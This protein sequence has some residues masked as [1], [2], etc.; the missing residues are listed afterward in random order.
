[1]DILGSATGG[2]HS[3]SVL[4]IF[5][6]QLSGG[7]SSKYS[8]GP[9]LHNFELE[10]SRGFSTFLLFRSAG[11]EEDCRCAKKI[12]IFGDLEQSALELRWILVVRLHGAVL[13]WLSWGDNLEA[14]HIL[15][16]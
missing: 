12:W 14:V 15:S 6:N 4:V 13:L 7:F 5:K 16:R 2:F 1:M 3:I 11:R 9:D 8:S 10:I